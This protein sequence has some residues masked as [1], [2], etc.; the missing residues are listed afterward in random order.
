MN[1]KIEIGENLYLV[2][3]DVTY[4]MGGADWDRVHLT[5]EVRRIGRKGKYESQLIDYECDKD[6]AFEYY[7]ELLDKMDEGIKCN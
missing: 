7:H 3:E 4:D 2:F 1:I 6:L 5:K